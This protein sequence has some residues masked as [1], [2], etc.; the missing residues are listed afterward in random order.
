[1]QV[2]ART[3]REVVDLAHNPQRDGRTLDRPLEAIANLEVRILDQGPGG[4]NFTGP[5][6]P[7]TPDHVVAERSRV[8]AE[9]QGRDGVCDPGNGDVRVRLSDHARGLRL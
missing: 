5:V 4:H 1:Q 9:P 7:A 6:E 2:A 3:A 8:S